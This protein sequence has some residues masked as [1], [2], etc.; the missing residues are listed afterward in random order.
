MGK[1]LI[2]S[3]VN[4]SSLESFFVAAVVSLLLTRFYLYVTGFPQVGGKGLHIAHMLWGGLLMVTAIVILLTYTGRT[5][6]RWA[7]IAGGAGF[8]LF[9]DELGKF[10]T[11]NTNYFFRPAAAIIY[12][13]FILLYLA[14]RLLLRRQ[15]LSG[16]K[17]L[18]LGLQEF[19]E[20]AVHSYDSRLVHRTKEYLLRDT[21]DRLVTSHLIDLLD[22]IPETPAQK[23]GLIHRLRVRQQRRYEVLVRTK[24]FPYAVVA[25]YSALALAGV[26]AA[27]LT[28][29]G[30]LPEQ[31]RHASSALDTSGVLLG[32]FASFVLIIVGDVLLIRSRLDAYRCYRIAMLISIFL[33]TLFEFYGIQFYALIG[34]F[35]AVGGLIVANTLIARERQHRL[36]STFGSAAAVDAPTDSVSLASP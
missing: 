29:F 16:R 25:V 19:M 15:H 32:S 21:S 18:S 26:A 4:E 1:Y 12:T 24:W 34:L 36:K 10:I 3:F 11:S 23:P 31:Q 6:A 22:L 9:I 30:D 28:T 17:Q 13:V 5:A 33:T 7:S 8:G 2:P 20:A 35:V 27:I 14:I